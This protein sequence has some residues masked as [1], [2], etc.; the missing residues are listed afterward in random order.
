MVTDGQVANV[1]RDCANKQDVFKRPTRS[2]A[3][4]FEAFGQWFREPALHV[5]YVNVSFWK[6]PVHSVPGKGGKKD[7]AECEGPTATSSHSPK[8]I[9]KSASKPREIPNSGKYFG[10]LYLTLALSDC[11]WSYCR[12]ARANFEP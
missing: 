6:D 5:F 4:E 7:I 1:S 10:V 12:Q 2:A 3:G 8:M 9:L 11:C